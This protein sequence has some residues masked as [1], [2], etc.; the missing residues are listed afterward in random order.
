VA[1]A[2][3]AA[4]LVFDMTNNSIS[5]IMERSDLGDRGKLEALVGLL[6][7]KDLDGI[8][9]PK[10]FADLEVYFTYE[11]NRRTHVSEQ[12]IQRLMN[13]L[14]DGTKSKVKHI[15]DDFNA[16]N[17]GAGKIN[18]L[19][20]VIEKARYNGRTVEGLTEAYR[21]NEELLNELAS[22][23]GRLTADEKQEV[24]DARTQ[25]NLE[26]ERR[27]AE[28]KGIMKRLF[29]GRN[30]RL[31]EG[32][33]DPSQGLRIT[34][35]RIQKT[36]SL[37]VQKEAQRDRNL[38]DGE[39]T[40]LRTVDATEFGLS[41]Q[42]LKTAHDSLTLI[43]DACISI[44]RL[45]NAN[46][47]SRAAC[48]GFTTT[49]NLAA[50]GDTILRDALQVVAEKTHVQGESLHKKPDNRAVDKAA[51][52]GDGSQVTLL[53]VKLDSAMQTEQHT[54]DDERVLQAKIVSLEML[55]SANKGSEA[56]VQQ[57]SSL[58]SAQHNLLSNLQ[59]QALAVAARALAMGLQRGAV[60]PD[61]LLEVW[62]REITKKARDTFG[63]NLESATGAQTRL[64]TL[65]R[66]R[67]AI[68]ALRH[69]HTLVIE[70]NDPAI[71][72]DL[73]SIEL[74]E[75]VETSAD[76]MRGAMGEFEKVDAGLAYRVAPGSP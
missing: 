9:A 23:R 52:A 69:A 39:L 65:D 16:V 26:D 25:T 19:L 70:R 33:Y 62:V 18:Q 40:I 64:E 61:G 56:R 44:E 14:A 10:I 43:E 4:E 50:A 28:D 66:M 60:L 68:A 55:A 21:F 29:F 54:L 5:K 20:K 57:F 74:V 59:Q 46:A 45:I 7:A 67:T 53:T 47:S 1:T 31:V 42:V 8:A 76:A 22:L 27:V 15:L 3:P 30:Q 13:E 32:F 6:E 12:D 34:Q 24:L 36:Q 73:G 37:I 49:L 38:E 63:A 58:I 17:V 41:D 71:E 2:A 72:L 48:T 51:V 11:Q 35:S 75:Q